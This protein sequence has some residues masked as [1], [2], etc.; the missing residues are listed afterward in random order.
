MSSVASYDAFH[1]RLTAGWSDTD[2]VFENESY[3]L[4]KSPKAFV[5]IEIVGADYPQESI[6]APGANLFRESGV[7]YLHVMVPDDT[8]SRVA[9]GHADALTALFREK[10]TDGVKID[11]MAIGSG[12]PG[13]SFANY[14]ALTVTL[15]WHR[16]EFTQP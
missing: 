5:Y 4:P 10:D 6:G 3:R 7:T 9:R 11:D 13:R 8:G 2:L 1:A 15:W 16:H 12:D 14:W